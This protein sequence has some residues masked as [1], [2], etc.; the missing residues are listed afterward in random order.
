MRVLVTGGTGFIGSHTVA[1]LVRAGHE[2][3]MLVRSPDRIATALDPLG[4]KAP[5][6]V[7]GDVTD[8]ASVEAAARGC[9]A[10]IHG[11]AVF[12]LDRSRD[13]EVAAT[14]VAGAE[15]VLGVAHRLGLDPIVFVSSLSA[16]FPPTGDVL[17]PDSPVQAPKEP[18]FES[19]P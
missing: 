1:A 5:E 7:V 18:L 8:L 2:V 17:T 14:N 11:A 16:L 3:R 10:A 13:D 15:N 19:A 9:D 6:H 12:T 4:V